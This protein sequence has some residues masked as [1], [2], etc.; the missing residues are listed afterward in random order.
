MTKFTRGLTFGV[1][2]ALTLVCGAVNAAQPATKPITQFTAKETL[3]CQLPKDKQDIRSISLSGDNRSVAVLFKRTVKVDG[4]DVDRFVVSVNGVEQKPYDWIV[5]NSLTFAADKATPAYIVQDSKGMYP[6]IGGQE[7]KSYYEIVNSQLFSVPGGRQFAYYVKAKSNSLAAAVIG[8]SEG[9]EFDEIGNLLFTTDGKRWSYAVR[10]RSKMYFL[11]DGKPGAE[12]DRVGAASFNWSPDGTRY[13]YLALKTN[14]DNTKTVVVMG[15]K[16]GAKEV[17]ETTGVSRVVFS[18]D[19]KRTAFVVET[20]DK[21]AQIYVDGKADKTYNRI[22]GETV[23]FSPD[24]KRIAYLASRK[25]LDGK[26]DSTFYVLDGQEIGSFKRIVTGSFVF[27]PDSQ[28]SAFVVASDSDTVDQ[29]RLIAIIDGK[30]GKE[31]EDLNSAQFSPDSRRFAFQA[32]RGDRWYAVIDNN[33]GV[34]YEIVR[35]L[36]FS[37]D[38]SKM[39][40][41]AARKGQ[42][43]PVIDNVEGKSYAG[44]VDRPFSFSANGKH[45]AFEAQR[46]APA[47]RPSDTPTTESFFVV[48][49]YESQAHQGSLRGSR[50]I[51]D[52][53]SKLRS[54]IVRDEG[55]ILQMEMELPQ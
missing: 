40:F 53:D 39:A 34:G 21:Q 1:S 35:G 4:K 19:S 30:G 47:T 41:I 18:P 5:A 44:I 26:A 31:Y 10:D 9:K 2:L 55:K 6:V 17:L 20:A 12:Y 22:L 29:I 45:M 32:R 23:V 8:D 42:W 54:L 11:I 16:D 51:W 52:T 49:S 13:A 33:E 36:Q 25:G 28:H 27:S 46:E 3:V 14:G 7:G 38:S 50:I 48:D 37:P 24:S 15:D 43:F